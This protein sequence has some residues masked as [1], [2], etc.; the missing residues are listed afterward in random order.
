MEGNDRSYL[1]CIYMEVLEYMMLKC[2]LYRDTPMP[3][4]KRWSSLIYASEVTIRLL[5]SKMMTMPDQGNTV[6]TRID[7]N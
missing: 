6:D 7:K 2:Y 3:P 5:Q 1:H 4:N